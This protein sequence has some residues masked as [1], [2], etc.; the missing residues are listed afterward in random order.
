MTII[1]VA[2]IFTWVAVRSSYYILRFFA[3]VAWWAVGVWWIYNPLADAGSPVNDIMLTLAFFGGLALMLMMAWRTETINGSEVGR[4]NIRLPE[5][6]GG[7]SEE[8]E[9]REA[10]YRAR[11]SRDRQ[12]AYRERANSAIRGRRIPPR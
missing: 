3:G 5:F 10:Q 8:D 9:L 7:Q 11:T 1:I 2:G 6:L 12:E 4:F